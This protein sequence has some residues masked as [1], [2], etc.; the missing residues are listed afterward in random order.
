MKLHFVHRMRG[1]V[2]PLVLVLSRPLE[3]AAPSPARR[4]CF[5]RNDYACRGSADKLRRFSL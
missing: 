4:G 2:P 3:L 1:V 5:P